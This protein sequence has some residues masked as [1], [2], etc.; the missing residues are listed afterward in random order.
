MSQSDTT[1]GNADFHFRSERHAWVSGLV[2]GAL[3]SHPDLFRARPMVDH[4]DN[5]LPQVL[6]TVQGYRF[7]VLVEELQ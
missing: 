3:M 6:I 4:N 7:S 5:Q 2:A 1:I